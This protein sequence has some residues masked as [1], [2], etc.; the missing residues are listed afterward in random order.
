MDI[1]RIKLSDITVADRVRPTDEDYVAMLANSMAENGQMQP[2][3]IRPTPNGDT[4]YKLI[5][6]AHR[7]AAATLLE[8]TEIDATVQKLS[9]DEAELIE[10]DENLI[11]HDL[12]VLDKAISLAKRKD[13]YERLHPHTKHG[14]DRISNLFSEQVDKSGDL[15]FTADA[16]EKLGVSERSIERAVQMASKL[17]P[18]AMQALR[19][20]PAVNNQSH[21]LALCKLTPAEQK[22]AVRKVSPDIDLGAAIASVKGKDASAKEDDGGLGKLM[23]AF[24]SATPKAREGFFEDL[25]IKGVLK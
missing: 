1:Q 15:K 23:K 25:K 24:A 5:F 17:D 18:A 11:R 7:H 8:W 14:G 21:L 12:N 16:A 19:G 4:P 6:G 2:I 13:V 3:L 22:K 9:A 10:I 20:T